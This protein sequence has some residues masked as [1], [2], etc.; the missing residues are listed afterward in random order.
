MHYIYRR[1]P[2]PKCDFNKVANLT[3]AWVFSCKFAAYFQN[4]FSQKHLW[5]AASELYSNH[6]KFAGYFQNTF[7]WEHI[8]RAVSVINIFLP[9]KVGFRYNKRIIQKT[10]LSELNV[11]KEYWCPEKCPRKKK[12]RENCPRKNALRTIAHRKIVLLDFCCF[13]HYHIVVPFKTFYGN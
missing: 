2:L 7:L 5:M 1:T 11:I 8:R 10:V 9:M 12:P 6:N 3:L 4:T 13:W